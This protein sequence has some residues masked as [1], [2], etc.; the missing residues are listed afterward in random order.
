M[1]TARSKWR[2]S[3]SASSSCA[4]RQMS[5]AAMPPPS[6]SATNNGALSRSRS[7][8]LRC[9]PHRSFYLLLAF[10]QLFHFACSF[11]FRSTCSGRRNTSRKRTRSSTS[12]ASSVKLEMASLTPEML[13][14]SMKRLS[15]A[16]RRCRASST[17]SVR[18]KSASSMIGTPRPKASSNAL[19]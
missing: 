1:R 13:S 6:I 3:R 18:A 12:S 17:A 8:P 19:V 7:R 2:F 5:A 16:R 9:Q 10:L 11:V 4:S 14:H 15:P